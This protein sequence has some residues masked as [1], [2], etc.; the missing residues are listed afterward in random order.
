VSIGRRLG[1]AVGSVAAGYA[2]EKEGAERRDAQRCML[3]VLA[4]NPD[5]SEKEIARIA[6]ARLAKEHGKNDRR[7]QLVTPEAVVRLERALAV[8]ALERKK[9]EEKEPTR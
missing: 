2:K 9:S 5:A 3:S 1:K 6:R 7:V 8:A 4:E